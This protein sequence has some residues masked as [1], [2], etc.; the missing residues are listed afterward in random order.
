MTPPCSRGVGDGLAPSILDD[1][2]FL[3]KIMKMPVV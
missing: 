1:V 2:C 3:E